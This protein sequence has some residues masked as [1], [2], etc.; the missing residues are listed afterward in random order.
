MARR[1]VVVLVCDLCKK[2]EGDGVATY[3]VQVNRKGRSVEACE[4][5][6]GKVE[7]ALAPVMEKGRKRR[8][9][10]QP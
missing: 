8:K 10:P 1:E 6:W 2:A 9:S 5:C 4:R 3:E 7:R